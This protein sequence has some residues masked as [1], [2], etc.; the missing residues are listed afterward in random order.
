[1]AQAYWNRHGLLLFVDTQKFGMN[2][3]ADDIAIGGSKGKQRKRG[4]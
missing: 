1:M 2:D 3:R 4:F